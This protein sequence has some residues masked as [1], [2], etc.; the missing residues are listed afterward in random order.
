MFGFGKAHLYSVLGS[1]VAALVL[2]ATPAGAETT[3]PGYAEWFRYGEE[4]EQHWDFVEAERTAWQLTI[5]RKEPDHTRPLRRVFVLY[6]RPS[7]AYDV[8]ITKILEVFVEKD[9]S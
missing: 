5:Q 2:S 8:A 7:S 1:L 3:D 4:A 9:R 6:P